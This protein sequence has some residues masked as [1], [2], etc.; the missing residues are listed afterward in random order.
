[1]NIL[2][3]IVYLLITFVITIKVGRIIYRNGHCY[4]HEILAGDDHLGD[5]INKL[6]LTGYYLFN[7]GYATI[8]IYTWQDVTSVDML[9]SS[10]SIMAGRIVLTLALMHYM[11]MA[12]IYL[13]GRSRYYFLHHKNN[14]I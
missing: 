5:N 14:S 7:L 8:M 9:I 3:Y 13:F 10:V 1:M 2:A 4:I 6:L 11:N 12:A